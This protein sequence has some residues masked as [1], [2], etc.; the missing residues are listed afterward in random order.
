MIELK[1]KFKLNENVVMGPSCS[2]AFTEKVK[3]IN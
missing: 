1:L 2:N 3:K